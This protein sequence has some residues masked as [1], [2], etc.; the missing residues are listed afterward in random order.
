M[1]LA[2]ALAIA[3]PRRLGFEVQHDPC[4]PQEPDNYAHSLIIGENDAEKCIILAE[5]T[6]VVYQPSHP[7]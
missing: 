6:T 7:T 3:V 4:P 2:V 5:E 1:N